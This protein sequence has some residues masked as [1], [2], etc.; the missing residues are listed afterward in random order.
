MMCC[1]RPGIRSLSW[2][3]ASQSFFPGLAKSTIRTVGLDLAG[4][5][6]LARR[7]G[8][9][10]H[11]REHLPVVLDE[12]MPGKARQP[13][14]DFFDLVRLHPVIDC[15]AT[16][17][18]RR[19]AQHHLG[20]IAPPRIGGRLVVHIEAQHR[21]LQRLQMREQRIFDVELLVQPKG[22]RRTCDAS[23]PRCRR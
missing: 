11:P 18:P 12:R 7:E 13:P 8:L 22:F 17:S 2:L 9:V 10:G 14:D 4:L 23:A 21:P 20:K 5:A 6:V 1:S 19:F 15:P 16:P 3:T